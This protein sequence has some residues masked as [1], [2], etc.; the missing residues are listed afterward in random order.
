MQKLP[1]ASTNA[2]ALPQMDVHVIRHKRR[3]LAIEVLQV[4]PEAEA[5]EAERANKK[6][7][8]AGLLC[9]GPPAA[10]TPLDF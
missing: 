5:A 7:S 10:N 3:R 1:R 4:D 8:A 2:E 6:S 9:S